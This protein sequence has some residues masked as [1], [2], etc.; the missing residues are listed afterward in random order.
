MKVVAVDFDGV[1][2]DHKNK[3]IHSKMGPPIEGAFHALQRLRNGYKIVIF[4][5]WASDPE[6]REVIAGWL[7]S[8][9]MPFDEITNI[10]PHAEFYIDDKAVRFT[11]WDEVLDFVL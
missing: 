2:H 11:T 1:V 3:P 9:G 4:C 8:Y 10:K 6:K 5:V 7:R